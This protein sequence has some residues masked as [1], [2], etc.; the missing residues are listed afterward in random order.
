[1]W[2]IVRR[3]RF[4]L[5][6]WRNAIGRVAGHHL[7]DGR[8]VIEQ[9]G[10]RVTHRADQSGFVHLLGQKRHDFTEPNAG[11]LGANRLEFA[12]D[13][14]RGVRFGVPNVN[15][16]GPALEEYEDDRFGFAPAIFLFRGVRGG[17]CARLQ[18]Q[19]IGQADAEDARAADAEEFATTE[20]I[21]RA[22]RLTR[23]RYHSCLRFFIC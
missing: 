4:K 15:V 20:A 21:A 11:N 7:I 19:D 5:P 23:Y 13:I 10:G 8:S 6:R 17:I 1:M 3:W 16:A 14:G 2:E 18:A 12:A 9:S 22:A